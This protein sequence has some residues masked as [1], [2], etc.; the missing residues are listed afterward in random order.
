MSKALY[1]LQSQPAV[2]WVASPLSTHSSIGIA[3]F[4]MKLFENSWLGY[5][6]SGSMA[7][8]PCIRYSCGQ[9]TNFQII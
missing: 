6:F 9:V 4:S 1:L 8:K 5:R 7:L 3:P 2:R